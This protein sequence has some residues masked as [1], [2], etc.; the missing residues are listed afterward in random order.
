[1]IAQFI[2]FL[3]CIV[4]LL[5]AGIYVFKKKNKTQ[6]LLF[7]VL[8]LSAYYF[9]AVIQYYLSEGDYH[10]SVRLDVLGL[11]CG[12]ALL[13]V[14]FL[15]VLAHQYPDI[16]RRRVVFLLFLPAVMYMAVTPLLYYLVTFEGAEV[17][18]R[19]VISSGAGNVHYAAPLHQLYVYLCY[20]WYDT[21]ALLSLLATMVACINISLKQGYHWGAGFRFFFVKGVCTTPARAISFFQLLL[22]LLFSAFTILDMLGSMTIVYGA[23]IMLL[24]AICCHLMCYVEYFGNISVFSLVNLAHIDFTDAKVQGEEG[25]PAPSSA[26]ASAPARVEHTLVDAVRKAFDEEEVYRDA[27]LSVVSLAERLGT[28]RTTLSLV[29]NQTYGVSFRQV[30]NNYRI[31]AAK[32]YMLDHPDATQEA[33]ASA[34]GFLTAQS[35]NIKFKEIVGQSPRVWLL[36]Q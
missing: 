8:L 24:V 1:M 11:P 33:V 2:L 20:R 28:N 17:I 22:L 18:T 10:L 7:W 14:N 35:F 4:S 15:Y 9:F 16:T 32:S 29:I 23:I 34:C 12:L 27:D 13:A 5:W 25:R 21:L 6:K 3:P 36:N 30:I 26:E 31:E 19:Q